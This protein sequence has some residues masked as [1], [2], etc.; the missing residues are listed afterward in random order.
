MGH[1]LRD[2]LCPYLTEPGIKGLNCMAL[3]R[4][5]KEACSDVC[6]ALCLSGLP[7]CDRNKLALLPVFPTGYTW[8]LKGPWGSGWPAHLV[9]FPDGKELSQ[10]G[11]V[12]HSW[13]KLAP[14][15]P[16]NSISVCTLCF[17]CLGYLGSSHE[18]TNTDPASTNVHPPCHQWGHNKPAIQHRTSSCPAQPSPASSFGHPIQGAVDVFS[19]AAGVMRITNTP[20]L[21]P[22]FGADIPG[23]NS[24]EAPKR[25]YFGRLSWELFLNSSTVTFVFKWPS[26]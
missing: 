15:Y 24:S 13:G 21:H 11:T 18:P 7:R 25:I 6:L 14:S 2:A 22:S 3:S 12:I 19:S 5:K 16:H 17:C 8:D 4:T 23:R 10:S 1:W 9:C 26:L 20:C